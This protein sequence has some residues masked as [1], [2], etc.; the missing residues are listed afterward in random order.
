MLSPQRASSQACACVRIYTIP[1]VAGFH[2]S[3]SHAIPTHSEPTCIAGICVDI[4]S[5]VAR[6]NITVANN[7]ILTTRT[8]TFI[9][10]RTADSRHYHHRILHRIGNQIATPRLGTDI[11]A[12]IIINEITVVAA[13]VG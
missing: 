11:R 1:I 5:I 7:P 12:I 4:V 10:T 2:P 6:F 3:L 9:G 8:S 13:S